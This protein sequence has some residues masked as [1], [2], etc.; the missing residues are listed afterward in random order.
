MLSGWGLPLITDSEHEGLECQTDELG[1]NAEGKE[2]TEGCRVG[3]ADGAG[4]VRGRRLG[5]PLCLDYF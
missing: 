2:A 5:E 3:G 4:R 1:I